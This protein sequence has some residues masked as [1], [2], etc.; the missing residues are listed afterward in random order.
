MRDDCVIFITDIS[1]WYRTCW[2]SVWIR[3]RQEVCLSYM[4]IL[5]QKSS[6]DAMWTSFLWTL[7]CPFKEVL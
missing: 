4:F 6:A 1:Q 5:P 2:P 3:T 7:Y